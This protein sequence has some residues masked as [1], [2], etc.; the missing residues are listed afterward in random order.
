[1]R[2]KLL[3]APSNPLGLQ[4]ET[5]AYY[6]GDFFTLHDVPSKDAVLHVSRSGKIKVTV[7]DASGNPLD[8]FQGN[9]IMVSV[10]PKDGLKVGTWG[11]N[12][13]VR[14]DGTYE[15]T[16]VP[17]GEYRLKTQPNPA[18]SS[19]VHAPEQMVNLEPGQSAVVTFVYR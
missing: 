2:S 12:A 16:G 5:N 15:F 14:K 7:T 9:E 19:K 3:S 6:F 8:K 17:A 18:N 1:M 13:T 4:Y 11:G 10:E